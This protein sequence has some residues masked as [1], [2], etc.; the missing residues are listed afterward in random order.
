[1]S[2]LRA[3]FTGYWN[4]V[5]LIEQIRSK[6]APQWGIFAQLLRGILDSLLLYLPIS[7]MGRVPP[8]PSFLSFLPTETYFATLIWMSPVVLLAELL[9]QAVVLHVLLRLLG[10]PSDI[11]QI[12]N[13]GGMSA[14]VVGA[15][16]IPWD[17]AW[18][19]LGVGDQYF[20][21]ISHL[22]ISLWATVIMVTGLKRILSV[23]LWLGIVLSIVTFAIGLPLGIMFMRS[24]L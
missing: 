6:P 22:V 18:V 2:F 7:L 11:D 4:P 3:W 19:A 16:L 13:I 5:A 24:P 14:L 15:V 21:G 20:L 1:M 17:W 8:T 9:L 10:R 23:P 12:I